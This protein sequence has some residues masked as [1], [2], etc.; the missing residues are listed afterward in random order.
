MLQ[1]HLTHFTEG[2]VERRVSSFT[3]AASSP[4]GTMIADLS[5]SHSFGDS[6]TFGISVLGYGGTASAEPFMDAAALIRVIN[7]SEIFSHHCSILVKRP[8]KQN[9][10]LAPTTVTD[11]AN[12]RGDHTSR[13]VDV[14]RVAGTL[15]RT[16]WGL[17]DRNPLPSY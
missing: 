13:T 8:W 7:P 17:D 2:D 6:G 12:E 3:I 16:Q 15:L 9:Q 5:R 1:P 14:D 10:Q 4:D 11:G